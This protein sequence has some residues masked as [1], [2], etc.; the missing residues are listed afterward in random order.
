[1]KLIIALIQPHKLPDVKQALYDSEVYRIADRIIGVDKILFGS[2]Y[3]LL[4]PARY[5]SELEQT[6]LTKIKLD[7][8]KGENARR[9]LNIC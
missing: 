8:I 5:F 9:L 4:P 6:G 2:D 7:K 1:M 3:P